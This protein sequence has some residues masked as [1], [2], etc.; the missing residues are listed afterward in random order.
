MAYIGWVVLFAFFG[1]IMAIRIAVRARSGIKG[2]MFEDALAVIFL[3]PLAVM[4]EHV[5]Y[6]TNAHGNIG[7]ENRGQDNGTHASK[8]HES[9]GR[10]FEDSH[11]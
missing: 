6:G 11:F 5:F 8:M 7:L 2:S 9:N 4:H 1:Y 10:K 3:Y